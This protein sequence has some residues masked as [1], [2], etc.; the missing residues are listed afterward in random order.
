MSVLV[1]NVSKD[2]ASSNL[3]YWKVLYKVKWKGLK[4]YSLINKLPSDIADI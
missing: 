3:F 2:K 4:G 1:S